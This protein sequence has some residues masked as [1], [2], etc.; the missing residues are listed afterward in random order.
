MKHTILVV[1][2][3]EDIRQTVQEILEDEGYTVVCA[4]EVGAALRAL[5]TID[6]LC[7]V[8][9]DLLMPGMNGWDFLDAFR[10]MPLGQ[11]T[12]VVI[13]SSA[14]SRAPHFATRVLVKPMKLVSLLEAAH[15]YCPQA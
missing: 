3:D 1:E 15:E 11:R 13:T 5:A 12:P 2:D 8:F 6:N 4:A 9:L 7:L 14:P 10:A